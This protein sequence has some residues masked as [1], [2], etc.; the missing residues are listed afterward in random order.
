MRVITANT[1]SYPRIGHGPGQMR[2]REAYQDWEKGNISDSEL[3]E[4]YKDYTK[5]VINEQESAGLDVVTDGLLR[6]YD[7]FSHF[8][9]SIDG[10]EIN[11]LLRY[12]D[13]NF[14]FRQP[15]IE[16]DIERN[17]SII[18]EEFESAKK[19]TDK[20]LKP[21]LTGP[22]T[23]AKH[24]INQY[25]ENFETLV[26]DFAEIISEEANRLGELG[27]EEVQVNEPAIL[28]N[29][30]DYEIFSKGIEIVADG[31]ENPQL[32]LYVF[33]EDSAPLYEDLQELPVDMLGLDFTYSPELVEIIEDRGSDKKLGLGLINARN[34][35]MENVNEVAETVMRIADSVNQD[36]IYLNPSCG[37]EFLPRKRAYEKLVNMEKI[38]KRAE[39]GIN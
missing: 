26:E 9:K 18:L 27:A 7:P 17:E 1:G 33:F 11:G 20:V 4:V 21:V 2:L 30:D 34:T 23:L 16:D 35:K 12:F 8:A 10:C 25:Y 13:T 39:E 5:E 31:V 3:E 19:Y 32:D 15:V 37:I 29:Q 14:Y 28:R 24:S 22:Y 6:W 36:Q 38:A